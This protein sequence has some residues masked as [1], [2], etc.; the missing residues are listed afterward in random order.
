MQITTTHGRRW[1]Q[2]AWGLA[3]AVVT[4]S[5]ASGRTDRRHPGKLSERVRSEA[6]RK[7]TA[8]MNVI[9][10]FRRTPGA[11]ERML[12]QGFGGQMRRHLK[13]SSRW[14]AVQLPAHLVARMSD[15]PIVDFVAVVS[16]PRILDLVPT[17][18]LR[19]DIHGRPW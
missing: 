13:D 16:T 18:F 11:P 14:M 2:L 7:G 19:S 8:K 12:V 10:R 9:V 3:L 15:N 4:V 17:E 6:G 5:V 1:R